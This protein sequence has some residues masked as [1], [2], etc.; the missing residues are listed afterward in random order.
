MNLRSPRLYLVLGSILLS[1]LSTTA[2]S[3]GPRPLKI[4][5]PAA[6]P[7]TV[8]DAARMQEIDWVAIQEEA[9][10]L[11]SRY[12]QVPSVNGDELVAGEFM[13]Q[14]AEALGFTV[15]RLDGPDGRPNVLISTGS[16]EGPP[17]VLLLSHLD[18]VA[19]DPDRWTHPPFSGKRIDGAV[20][21]R[22]SIDNKGMTVMHL[23]ALSLLKKRFPDYPHEIM[24]LVVSD[25]E[26]GGTGARHVVNNHGVLFGQAPVLGEGGTGLQ[27]VDP[28]PAGITVY[29]IA[30]AEKSSFFIDLI[31]ELSSSGHGSVPPP[32][33]ASLEMVRALN[34]LL[35]KP[36]PM[37]IVPEMR[38]LLFQLA[39]Y[40]K[41]PKNYF[42]RRASWKIL[43]PILERNLA[44]NPL[45]N[46]MVRDTITLTG[47]E[48]ETVG[49]N[50]SIPQRIKARLDCRLL[51]GSNP[52]EFIAR[53][54]RKLNNPKIQV[55]IK[56]PGTF[57]GSSEP[58]DFYR[59]LEA[60]LKQIEPDAAVSRFLFPASS[61]GNTFRA[62]GHKMF[63]LLP[64]ELTRQELEAV[65]G[66]DERLREESLV[67][68]VRVVLETLLRLRN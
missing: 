61:D 17:R 33:Y 15:R 18:V 2:L 57:A 4:E 3:G 26:I 62:A 24:M 54:K 63:G 31:L 59:A 38:D 60:S 66:P 47:V 48:T 45:T 36:M 9:A 35:E 13:Q 34:R 39:R 1:T 55:V 8:I 42:M 28:V 6:P 23:A 7:L 64:C 68:G 22:G 32:E 19:V 46:A 51:P 5:S 41:F 43:R 25:E 30:T 14:T 52:D 10:D 50:N 20:W 16:G 21:G 37:R 40:E 44:A 29:P 49:G 53:M 27:G 12:I 56:K 65:H 11:L 58:D 67:F